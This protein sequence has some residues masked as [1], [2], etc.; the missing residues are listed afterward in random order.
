MFEIL[1]TNVELTE[2]PSN[3]YEAYDMVIVT[4]AAEIEEKSKVLNEMLNDDVKQQFIEKW[5]PEI[6]NVNIHI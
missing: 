2:M 1:N 4:L 3:G 6:T 5:T